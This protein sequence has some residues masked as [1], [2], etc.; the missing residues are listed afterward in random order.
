MFHRLSTG[1]RN[2]A[3]D[4]SARADALM[5]QDTIRLAVTGL[6]RAGKTVFVTSL[7]ANLLALGR[8]LDT[9]PRL[10]G[11]LGRSL[12]GES[13]GQ[14]ASRLQGICLAPPGQEEVP[15]FDLARNLGALT[16]PA[17]DWP[18]RTDDL[19]ETALELTLERDGFLGRQRGPRRLRLEILD[20]P[21]E[22]LLDLPLLDQSFAE[23]S[24]QTLPRLCQGVRAQI[25]EGFLEALRGHAPDSSPDHAIVRRVHETYREALRVAQHEHGLRLLQ[26][27]RLLCPGPGADAPFLW[28]FPLEGAPDH[29][30]RGTLADLLQGR[31]EAYKADMRTRFFERHFSRFDRQVL[32]VDVL[33]ALHGG[34]EV[35]HDTQDALALIASCLSYGGWYPG[36]ARYGRIARVAFAATKADHVPTI[37]RQNLEGLLKDIVAPAL[38]SIGSG[39]VSYHAVASVLSTQDAVIEKDGVTH[40]VVRGTILGTGMARLFDPGA[41]P[42]SRPPETFWNR[43]RFVLPVFEPP[44]GEAI[45]PT[46][47]PSLGLDTLLVTLLGDKL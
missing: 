7:L 37:H 32:L 19:T 26:P 38:T 28:F 3:Y 39:P 10:H 11:A 4:A 33:G 9:L 16:A 31:F 24:R 36:R 20:Y 29:P 43:R 44:R 40:D 22:W 23:W 5:N 41:V 34:R 30:R 2:G 27:G 15:L 45:G 35:F 21:G 6:S 46:G 12:G 8:G 17:P 18:P 1:L 42:A 13:G 25:F 14:M 47:I